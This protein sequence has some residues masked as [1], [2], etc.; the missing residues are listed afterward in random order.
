M[1]KILDIGCGNSKIPGAV[2]IDISATTQADVVHNLNS[3]PWPFENN[4]FDEI[5]CNDVLEH[6]EDVVA[7][8]EEIHR[9]TKESAIVKIRLPHFS[10]FNSYGDVTHKH[11]FN[12]QS[13]DFICGENFTQNHYSN[14]RFK[15]ICV[16]LTFGKLY[17]FVGIFANKWTEK[18]ERYFAFLFPAG[19]IE[20]ILQVNK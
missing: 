14:K 13:L 17:R 7:S 8:M 10:C 18:Y 2:G 16:K 19:N 12:S 11:M 15:K 4:T 6:L 5:I 9:I 3:F 1:K 20:I